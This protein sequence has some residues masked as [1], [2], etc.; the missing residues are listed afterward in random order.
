M[1]RHPVPSLLA[2]TAVAWV[3]REPILGMTRELYVPLSVEG[4]P[5]QRQRTKS[6]GR[7]RP[8]GVRTDE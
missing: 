8:K 7:G 4:R 3:P 1:I 5:I 2:G 6:G